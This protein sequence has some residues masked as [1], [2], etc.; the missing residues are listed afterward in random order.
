VHIF[1][2]GA[3]EHA[4]RSQCLSIDFGERS[5]ADPRDDNAHVAAN[6][7]V[8]YGSIWYCLLRFLFMALSQRLWSSVRRP[9]RTMADRLPYPRYKPV[10]PKS[11]DSHMELT[12]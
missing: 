3:A 1:K 12:P 11:A 8:T 7:L 10:A 2:T 5:I 4:P 9:V 6:I